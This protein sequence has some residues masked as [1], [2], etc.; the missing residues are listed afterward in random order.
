MWK[1]EQQCSA[2][3]I[4]LHIWNYFFGCLMFFCILCLSHVL[5]EFPRR[6]V[7][8]EESFSKRRTLICK[9]K[10]RI[11]FFW[12]KNKGRGWTSTRVVIN[13]LFVSAICWVQ[14]AM[15]LLQCKCCGV[16][17]VEISKNYAVRPVIAHHIYRFFMEKIQTVLD[18]SFSWQCPFGNSLNWSGGRWDVLRSLLAC[19]W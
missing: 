12:G 18:L 13:C 10:S 9:L 5:G 7:K 3:D 8:V 14:C 6:L 11:I 1:W 15:Q 19:I 2:S 16:G 17:W 4:C